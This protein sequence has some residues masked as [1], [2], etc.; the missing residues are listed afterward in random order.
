M[1]P[2]FLKAN[3]I[4]R[5]QITEVVV[6]PSTFLALLLRFLSRHGGPDCDVAERRRCLVGA[7]ICVPTKIPTNLTVT[8]E[9]V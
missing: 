2:A 5:P 4:E 9:R 1:Y 6:S 8:Q 7:K 3:K